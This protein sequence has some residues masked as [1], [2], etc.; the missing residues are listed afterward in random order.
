MIPEKRMK[1]IPKVVLEQLECSIENGYFDRYARLLEI[2]YIKEDE[3]SLKYCWPSM[4]R[5][6]D[7]YL[8]RIDLKSL[9][10][11]AKAADSPLIPKHIQGYFAEGE[12]VAKCY[13]ADI[14]R[15]RFFNNP[16]YHESIVKFGNNLEHEELMHQLFAKV[17]RDIDDVAYAHLGYALKIWDRDSKRHFTDSG[18]QQ[19]RIKD[20]MLTDKINF[21]NALFS[22]YVP[23]L[24]PVIY[25]L[26]VNEDKI[27]FAKY[28]TKR[29]EL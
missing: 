17:I 24:D 18:M 25:G 7:F 8:K 15:Q 14:I 27:G 29:L 11:I 9:E 4:N 12:L 21:I 20:I 22:N 23:K 13:G 6:P 5:T 16:D 3:L 2:H 19:E 28:I 10:Q 26:R 1:D